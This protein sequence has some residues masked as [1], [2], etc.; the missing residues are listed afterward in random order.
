MSPAAQICGD[1]FRWP[2]EALANRPSL[3][4][5]GH[6][7]SSGCEHHKLATGCYR[8]N[9]LPG[10]EFNSLRDVIFVRGAVIGHF[11]RLLLRHDRR[12]RLRPAL[13]FCLK[14]AGP[15]ARGGCLAVQKHGWDS[16]PRSAGRVFHQSERQPRRRH[17]CEVDPSLRRP[18]DQPVHRRSASTGVRLVRLGQ[19][20]GASFVIGWFP[21][22]VIASTGQNAGGR[23]KPALPMPWRPGSRQKSYLCSPS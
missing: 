2:N 11:E 18:A 4:D 9:G 8:L 7:V 23:G 14:S 3:S 6:R 12:R 17:P 19:S 13:A 5:R 20:P 22:S 16:Q 1:V 21:F 15:P 10:S